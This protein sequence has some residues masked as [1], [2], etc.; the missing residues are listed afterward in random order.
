MTANRCGCRR[1]R[2]SAPLML[3]A[4]PPG[5]AAG[6]RRVGRA[7]WPGRSP[8]RV[9]RF[10]D[11][12]GDTTAVGQLVAVFRR[13]F[14]DGLILVP[15]G[16]DRRRRGPRG[17]TAVRGG[18]ADPGGGREVGVECLAEFAGVLLGQV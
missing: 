16:P 2:L 4:A 15:V 18:A 3:P 13:P 1:S 12:T 17:D 11:G 10:D 14:A 9:E 6:R 8:L 7:Q 5:V